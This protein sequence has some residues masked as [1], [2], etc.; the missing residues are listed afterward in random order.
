MLSLEAESCDKLKK[1]TLTPSFSQL[2]FDGRQTGHQS[3]SEGQKESETERE[4]E[5]EQD[6][7]SK[8]CVSTEEEGRKKK[9]E[10]EKVEKMGHF[11][12]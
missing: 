6:R 4:S 1:N 3:K 10:E 5:R 12:D 8:M 9:P 2:Y 11:C 7:K